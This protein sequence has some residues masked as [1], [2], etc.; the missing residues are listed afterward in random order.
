MRWR[1]VNESAQ[2][3]RWDRL[4]RHIEQRALKPSR[5]DA[6]TQAHALSD[7]GISP[8]RNNKARTRRALLALGR[9]RCVVTPCSS[10]HHRQTG[11]HR[12]VGLWFGN[13]GG[14]QVQRGLDR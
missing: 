13:G 8:T 4:S 12:G 1:N 11:Q 9:L 14:H 2:V 7:N 3:F 5:E 10:T 6:A